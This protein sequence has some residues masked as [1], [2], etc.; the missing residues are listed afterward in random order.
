MLSNFELTLLL[1]CNQIDIEVVV[2]IKYGQRTIVWA[3]IIHLGH[4]T[5]NKI[6]TTVAKSQNFVDFTGAQKSSL[7]NFWYCPYIKTNR[8]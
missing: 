8:Y 2:S 6:Y 5:H 4:H 1:S 3:K 7:E